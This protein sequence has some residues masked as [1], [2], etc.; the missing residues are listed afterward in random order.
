VQEEPTVSA[1]A[2][3]GMGEVRQLF[4]QL[5]VRREPGGKVVIEAPADAASTLSALFEGMAALL[6]S[7]AQPVD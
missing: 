6:Q 1:A 4:S 3:P 7:A 2:L 5:Q